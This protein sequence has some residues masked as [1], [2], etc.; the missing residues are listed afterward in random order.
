MV[1]LTRDGLR[2][3]RHL[4]HIATEL[5]AAQQ[6]TV[7]DPI[8][9][10]AVRIPFILHRGDQYRVFDAEW[11]ASSMLRTDRYRDPVTTTP[12]SVDELRDLDRTLAHSNVALP[13]VV[14]AA[15][16]A[17]KRRGTPDHAQTNSLKFALESLAG[18][19]VV[20]MRT[21][22]EDEGLSDED[23]FHELVANVFP[24]FH[25]HMHQL[26]AIDRESACAHATC[27][28]ELVR[29]PPNCRVAE[30]SGLLCMCVDSIVSV[31]QAQVDVHDV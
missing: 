11:L 17:A 15:G 25:M 1:C 2:R 9:L 5:T 20:K 4:Q 7:E 26:Q 29:G 23:V 28:V 8:S 31:R 14:V 16:R 13:S 18:E 10:Q 12:L 6:A 24:T 3:V 30:R 19:Q 27:L 21:L 22:L